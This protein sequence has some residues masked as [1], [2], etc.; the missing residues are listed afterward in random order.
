M[1]LAMGDS[2]DRLKAISRLFSNVFPDT[3]LA[4]SM[5]SLMGADLSNAN[6]IARYLRVDN[7]SF[8]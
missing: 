3:E 6:I 5:L 4:S 1:Q 2:Q 7:V 8:T